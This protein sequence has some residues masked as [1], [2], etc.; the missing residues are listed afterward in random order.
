MCVQLYTYLPIFSLTIFFLYLRYSSRIIFLLLE[1]HTILA[2]SLKK[3]LLI[4][5]S[6]LFKKKEKET[7]CHNQTRD[8]QIGKMKNSQARESC[9]IMDIRTSHP[10]MMCPLLPRSFHFTRFLLL[11]CM[12]TCAPYGKCP[13]SHYLVHREKLYLDLRKG[14]HLTQGQ[15]F[16]L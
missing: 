16:A 6:I 2:C 9:H 15:L 13:F 7:S 1:I 3:D 12:L 14:K 5:N 8:G 11:H 4:I 10:Y